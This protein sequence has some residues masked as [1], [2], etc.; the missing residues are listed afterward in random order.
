[1]MKKPDATTVITKE[2]FKET[3]WQLPVNELLYVG[4]AT[5]ARL[6][7]Y[8]IKTIGDLAKNDTDFLQQILGKNGLMLWKFANGYDTSLVNNIQVK[9]LVKSVGNSTTT[10][11]DLIADE[12]C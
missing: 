2:G 1:D 8:G 12:R 4:R 6:L 11:H 10:P 3:I 7:K 9:S 5:H